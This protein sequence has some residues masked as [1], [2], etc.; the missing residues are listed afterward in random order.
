M[1]CAP[2]VPPRKYDIQAGRRQHQWQQC[3]AERL[4]I[5]APEETPD[6][7]TPRFTATTLCLRP[8]RSLLEAASTN[9]LPSSPASR[10][11]LSR[12]GIGQPGQLCRH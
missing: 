12:W 2:S 1:N 10:F 3:R 5:T 11:E 7:P 4:R 9:P 8:D 6:N